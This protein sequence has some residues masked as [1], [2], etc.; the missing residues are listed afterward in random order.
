MF[1]MGISAGNH[2]MFQGNIILTDSA[3]RTYGQAGYTGL[4]PDEV[5][6]N[7]YNG[8]TLSANNQGDSAHPNNIM[9][10]LFLDPN[11]GISFVNAARKH[12]AY[13]RR[14]QHEHA[15][16]FRRHDHSP[17]PG[18]SYAPRRA[19]AD[20]YCHLAWSKWNGGRRG[21]LPEEAAAG[22]ATMVG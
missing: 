15:D 18:P 12:R 19:G 10:G 7:A 3:G 20:G 11:G 14:R 21:G 8:N 22:L 16:R 5:L 9:E 2:L 17:K 6:F 1:D 4:T 13:F